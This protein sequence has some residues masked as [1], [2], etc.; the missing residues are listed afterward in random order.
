MSSVP[1]SLRVQVVLYEPSSPELARLLRGV[2]AAARV[3]RRS[4]IVSSVTLALGDCSAV[5]LPTEEV[6]R[7]RGLTSG[8]V[9]AFSY[10]HFG[11]NLGSG[12]GHNALFEECDSDLV[13]VTNPDTYFA[14]DLFAPLVACVADPSVGI[15]EARQ[16]PLEHPKRYDVA[17]GDVSWASGA[18]MLLRASTYR[19]L[20]G[21]DADTFFLY[22]DDVDLSWRARLSGSRVVYVPRARVFHDKRLTRESTVEAGP[23]E[24]Y[25]SAEAAL[26]MAWKWS[27]PD[28]VEAWSRDLL[29]A[30]DTDGVRAVT[31]FTERRTAGRLPTPLD[32]DGAIATFVGRDYSRSQFFYY[33]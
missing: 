31:A 33:D 27:R 25:Y 1:P 17:T 24:R 30:G 14:P 11:E 20:R 29:A 16:L 5:P 13:F 32:A 6:E 8:H 9:D 3:A 19:E 10:R 4:E 26:L 21:F 22:C 2:A 28:L 12:G 23:A 15:A 18:C 7:A